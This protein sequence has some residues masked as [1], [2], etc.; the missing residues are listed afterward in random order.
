MAPQND[1][2]IRHRLLD[3]C[4]C[5]DDYRKK[6]LEKLARERARDRPS[7]STCRKVVANKPA[8]GKPNS[9]K[10]RLQTNQFTPT[11]NPSCRVTMSDGV[12]GI[13]VIGLC[14]DGRDDSVAT[15]RL[16]EAA[17]IKGIGR[18]N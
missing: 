2:G 4:D 15:P 17:V 10:R 12:A 16:A 9:P 13:T 18:I 7:K 6:L 1:R 11:T 3:F 14:D 5:P 8:S